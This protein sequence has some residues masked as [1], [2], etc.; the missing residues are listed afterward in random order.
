MILDGL[1]P[2]HGSMQ[3]QSISRYKFEYTNGRGRFDVF[4]F[5][6]EVPY[7]LLIGARGGNFAIN[8]NVDSVTFEISTYIDKFN[9]LCEFLGLEFKEGS[10]YSTSAFFSDLN[11][12]IPNAASLHNIPKP[13]DIAQYIDNVLEAD[14]VHFVGWLD[15]N[16]QGNQVSEQNLDKTRRLLGVDIYKICR[17]QNISSRWSP[18]ERDSVAITTPC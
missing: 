17:H 14:K 6:D 7:K 5:I 4:F 2:L 9:Q 10:P 16:I 3:A 11:S 1:I 13:S 15:N 8:L 18:H 12:N